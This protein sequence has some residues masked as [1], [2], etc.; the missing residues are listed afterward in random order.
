MGNYPKEKLM[1]RS[2]VGWMVWLLVMGGPVASLNLAQ[3]ATT[4][5]SGAALATLDI[6]APTIP[7]TRG[8]PAGTL[9]VAQHFGLSPK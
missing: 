1:Y 5:A 8:M 4:G 7:S 2:I 9:T 3:T 6:K